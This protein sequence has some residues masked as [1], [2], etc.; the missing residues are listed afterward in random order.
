MLTRTCPICDT[1]FPYAYCGH[2]AALADC[3]CGRYHYS[4]HM[5]GCI[6]TVDEEEIEFY[7]G[8][9]WFR[10]E[11][12]IDSKNKAAAEQLKKAIAAAREKPL[13]TKIESD[14]PSS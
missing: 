4:Q 5:Y 14:P 10:T 7:I 2:G 9:R 8:G 3:P 6:E 13:T 1:E 12:E 11:E